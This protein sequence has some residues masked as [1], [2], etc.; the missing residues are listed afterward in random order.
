MKL[1]DHECTVGITK[2][3]RVAEKLVA[4]HRIETVFAVAPDAAKGPNDSPPKNWPSCLFQSRTGSPGAGET[5][6]PDGKMR[7]QKNPAGGE[8]TRRPPEED[9][10]NDR[11]SG[12]RCQRRHAMD[13][14][15]KA[16]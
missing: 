12:P 4:G 15:E 9:H 13:L 7:T 14:D 6:D 5:N 10:G 11:R 16:V 3:G 2:R 1:Y 8:L